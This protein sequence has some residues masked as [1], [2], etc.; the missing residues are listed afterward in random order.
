MSHRGKKAFF[1]I[2]TGICLPAFYCFYSFGRARAGMSCADELKFRAE[3]I[4]LFIL[5]GAIVSVVLEVLSAVLFAVKKALAEQV[6]TGDGE[7]EKAAR[8]TVKDD[9][10]SLT[11][12]KSLRI[13]LAVCGAGFFTALVFGLLGYPPAVILNVMYL[14][15]CAGLLTRD[16]A[17]LFLY[18]RGASDD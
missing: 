2:L 9:R 10:D 16:L 8:E 18:G 12:L 6:T 17:R 1:S 3:M 13:C 5:I 15:F 7:E 4:L 14:S 11:E